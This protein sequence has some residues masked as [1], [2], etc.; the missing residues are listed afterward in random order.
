MAFKLTSPPGCP[1]THQPG[2]SVFPRSLRLTHVTVCLIQLACLG[3]AEDTFYRT[4]NSVRFDDR[5]WK[6]WISQRAFVALYVASHRGHSEAVQYLLEHGK[7]HSGW[8]CSRGWCS[9]TESCLTLQPHGLQ[10]ATLP[11]PSPSPRIS[12][13]SCPLRGFPGGSDSKASVCNT[14]DLGSIPESG[15]SPG[16]GNGN[17]L[18]YSSLV[19]PMDGGAW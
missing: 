12:S 2:A 16:E 1:G 14:G 4:E 18:Q 10:H 15:R 3:V 19:N 5:Q 7:S 17:P 9:V 13:N 8:V 6:K 11:C